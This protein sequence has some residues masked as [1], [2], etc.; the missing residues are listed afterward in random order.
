MCDKYVYAKV[1]RIKYPDNNLKKKLRLYA[2][3]TQK[4][5]IFAP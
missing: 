5:A 3:G 1:V 2:H 4:N